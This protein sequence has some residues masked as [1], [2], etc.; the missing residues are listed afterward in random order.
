MGE[1]A[2]SIFG[3]FR[4]EREVNTDVVVA[5]LAGGVTRP[6]RRHHDGRACGDTSAQCLVHAD[7]CGV[8]RAKVVTRNDDETCVVGITKFLGG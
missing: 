5:V 8:A 6:W 7:S 2:P 1:W 4:V 3:M